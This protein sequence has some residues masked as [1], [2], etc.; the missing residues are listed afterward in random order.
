MARR[1]TISF[2]N[3]ERSAVCSDRREISYYGALILEVMQRVITDHAV[4]L[5]VE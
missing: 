3:K 4:E 2:E 5:L 1:G